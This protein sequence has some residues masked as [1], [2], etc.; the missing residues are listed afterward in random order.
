M[1]GSYPFH[2]PRY[3]GQML[4]PPHPVAIAAYTAAMHV[5]ANNH[6]L[7]GGPATS[8]L[9]VEVVRDLARDVRLPG[10]RARPPDVH[11]GR[12]RTSRRCGW[13]ASCTRTRRSRSTATPTTRTRGCAP[14]SASRALATDDLEAAARER[15]RRHDRRHR[16]HD[17]PRAPSTPSRRR[18]AGATSYG[19]RVHVDAAYGGFFTLLDELVPVRVVP[20]DRRRRQRRRRPAQA[21]PAAL[22]VRRGALPRPRRRAALQARLAVHLLHQRRPAPRRDL[23]R[24]L[25]RRRRRGRALADAALARPRADPGRRRARR[26]R[27]GRRCCATPTSCA[28]TSSRSSTSSATSRTA[29]ARRRSTPRASAC[30]TPA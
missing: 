20:R 18:C 2:H 26:P 9:E 16:R 7:D 22:R 28:C 25:A 6:A 17:R 1:A 13:R 24:V 30:S 8:E 10:R 27:L 21:R 14:C 3:A 15:P 29:R 12:S 4:K 11:A 23:A 19:V 5:N